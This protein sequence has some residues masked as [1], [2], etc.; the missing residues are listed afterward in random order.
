MRKFT[1][2]ALAAATLCAGTGAALAQNVLP[3]TPPSGKGNYAGGYRGE[4]ER[5]AGVPSFYGSPYGAPAFGGP[6]IVD[7]EPEYTGT[8][9]ERPAY[10]PGTPPSGKGNY[11][12][13]Y[14]GEME[15][16]LGVE[17]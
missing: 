17:E 15:R 7:D 2:A 10:L 14:R 13:G 5:R 12:G 16:R 9:V 4:A 11:A 6:A 1:L 3:G 8:I